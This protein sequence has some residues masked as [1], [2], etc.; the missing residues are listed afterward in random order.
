MNHKSLR[1]D[2][3]RFLK[4]TG[5]AGLALG[6]AAAAPG[7][8]VRDALRSLFRK[9]RYTAAE[10]NAG[11]LTP[12]AGE[13]VSV[14]LPEGPM[15][16]IVEDVTAESLLVSD[17]AQHVGTS[18]KV[19]MAGSTATTL[20]QGTYQLE[21]DRVGAFPLFMVPNDTVP[22]DIQRYEAVFSRL[23]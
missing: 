8:P 17:S 4:A 20:P 16:L 6:A 14:V 5:Y 19:L 3:R 11:V 7:G 10:L 23:A 22:G 15:P 12:M 13:T 18:F 21:S 1:L 9:P 2:R